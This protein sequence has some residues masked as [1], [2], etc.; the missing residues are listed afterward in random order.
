MIYCYIFKIVVIRI[1]M[2]QP[3]FD[4]RCE[5]LENPIEIDMPNPRFSWILNHEKRNQFQSAYQIIVSSRETLSN[6]GEGDLWNIGKKLSQKSINIE[7]N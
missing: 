1:V 7:Y 5:Y 2:I 6:N 3:P 4:L